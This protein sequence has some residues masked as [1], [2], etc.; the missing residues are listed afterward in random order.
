[1]SFDQVKTTKRLMYRF[2]YLLAVILASILC[3]YTGAAWWAPAVT[4]AALA[5]L[6]PV[7]RRNGFWLAFIAGILVLGIYTG[8]LHLDSEG[9]L[10]D[11]LAV[12]FGVGNGW[13]LVVA[14]AIWG[15]LTAGLGGWFGASLRKVFE[16][17]Q[18][19][20]ANK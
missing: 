14:T 12:T 1:V 3:L 8:F 19:A 5:L 18:L 4:A 7:W 11:R 13:G 17:R 6:F 20:G 10:T 15:G 2:F 16:R 9:R